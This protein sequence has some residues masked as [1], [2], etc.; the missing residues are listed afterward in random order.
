M[1]GLTTALLAFAIEHWDVPPLAAFAAIL[2]FGAFTRTSVVV[3]EPPPFIVIFAGMF[4]ER[5][6]RFL[7]SAQSSAICADL[8][9]DRASHAAR[10][11][12]S[13]A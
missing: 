9:A 7:L 5:G 8:Y 11:T 3:F 4:L 10:L 6:A 13:L 1:I 2:L 12:S